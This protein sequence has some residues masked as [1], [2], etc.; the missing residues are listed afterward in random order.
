MSSHLYLDTPI[1]K[2]LI[3]GDEAIT[4]VTFVGEAGD[5]AKPTALLEEAAR[6]LDAYFHG[7][8]RTFD[9]PLAPAG[10]AFEQAV[11]RHL[12][13]IPYGRTTTYGEIATALGR[14]H[15]AARAVGAANA[16]N[17]IVIIIPCHRVI[18]R[19]GKL[20]G[21]GGGLWRKRWLLQH[22]G[23]LLL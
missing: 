18:G 11:W 6:Q 5:A 21:Y 9:L 4:R 15:A 23:A 8:L 2:L 1:G 7:E 12:L 17:P 10:S 16:R 20:V 19:G 22:E 3:V 13:T 14:G